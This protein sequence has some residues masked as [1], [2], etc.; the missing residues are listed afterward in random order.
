[1]NLTLYIC[2]FFLFK[3]LRPVI[4][5]SRTRESYREKLETVWNNSSKKKTLDL[6]LTITPEFYI[7]SD[8]NINI[9]IGF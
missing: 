5:Q 7:L 9:I 6:P 4:G 2:V 8:L 3:D 1:M